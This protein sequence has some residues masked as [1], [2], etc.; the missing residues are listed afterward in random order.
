MDKTREHHV[1]R[2][3][4]Y[5]DSGYTC[6]LPLPHFSLTRKSL[7]QPEAPTIYKD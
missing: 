5:M 7:A 4:L 2:H 3:R 6:V 1:I